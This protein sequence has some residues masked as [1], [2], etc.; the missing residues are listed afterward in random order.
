MKI[1][2][3][4][5]GVMGCLCALTLYEQHDVTIFNDPNSQSAS[6]VA[7][8]LLS[9]LT[10]LE[11]HHAIIHELG[12][13]SLQ[14]GWEKILEK[15]HEPVYFEKQGSLVLAHPNDHS[16]LGSYIAKITAKITGKFNAETIDSMQLIQLEPMLSKHHS[17]L[18]FPTEGQIDNQSFMSQAKFFLEKK[19]TWRD[20]KVSQIDHHKIESNN[21]FYSFD[22][23]LDCRGIGAKNRLSDLRGVRGE[24]IWLYAPTVSIKRPVRLLHPRYSLYVVPRPNHIYLIGASEIE[25]EDISEISVRTTLELLTAAYFIHPNF[26]EARI[27]KTMTGL[28]PTLSNHLPDVNINKELISIN[29]LSRHGFLIAPAIANDINNWLDG[30]LNQVNFPEIWSHQSDQYNNQSATMCM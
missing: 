27:L 10:E 26:A 23:V 30:G 5:G 8:G 29:G 24:M 28:R 15:I 19:I 6:M 7:A 20:W 13:Y 18:Y 16:E 21:I 1:G 25:S 17:A 14:M 2:I 12:T 22:L 4:G 11:K 3:V 9:P